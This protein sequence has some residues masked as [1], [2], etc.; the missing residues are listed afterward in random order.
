MI[1]DS[2]IAKEKLSSLT[3]IDS[4]AINSMTDSQLFS[5][6]Q[7]LNVTAAAFPLQKE[8]LVHAF[9]ENDYATVFQWLQVISSSLSQMH[10]DHLAKE[11]EKFLKVNNDLSNVKVPRLRVFIDYFVPTL[12]LFVKDVHDVLEELEVE[13]A[14]PPSIEKGRPKLRDLLLTIHDLDAEH[15]KQMHEDDED[16]YVRAVAAFPAEFQAQ[17]NGLKSS[18]KIKHYTFVMQWLNAVKESLTKIHATELAADCTKQ[19]AANKD[20]N[21][22][23]HEKLEVFINYLISSASMIATDINALGLTQMLE[24]EKAKNEPAK[25]ENLD[26]EIIAPGSSPDSK[27][28][29]IINKMTMLMNSLKNAMGDVGYRII[30]ATTAENAV[31]Y[32]KTSKPDLFIIDED[33]PGTDCYVLIK[34]IRATGQLSPIIF[35]ASKIKKEKMEKY[36]EAGVADFIMKP[37]SPADVRQKISKCIM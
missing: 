10:A 2:S 34:I 20:F 22:I 18:I 15:I 9:S 16:D 1:N 35:T 11:C 36:I 23:R 19:I 14:A 33:L 31:A 29:L 37:I 5:Y 8:E 32:L 30:G 24:K 12:D 25:Q 4:E 27:T 26:V 28:V 21:N 3:E 17:E 7:A 13:E 6:I